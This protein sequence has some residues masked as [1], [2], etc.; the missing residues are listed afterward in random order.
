MA[1]ITLVRHEIGQFGQIVDQSW[2]LRLVT[3]F[4]VPGHAIR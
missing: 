4:P 3:K 1:S 2:D